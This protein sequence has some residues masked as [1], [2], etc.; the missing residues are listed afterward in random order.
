MIRSQAHLNTNLGLT[1]TKNK[2]DKVHAV[3]TNEEILKFKSKRVKK[4]IS[5]LKIVLRG[6]CIKQTVY[7]EC[8][9]SNN[10]MGMN[11]SKALNERYDTH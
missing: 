1:I 6:L 11:E 5:V 7:T 4:L 3:G 10:K 8:Q 9:Y 2:C